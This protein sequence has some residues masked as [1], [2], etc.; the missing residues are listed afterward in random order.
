MLDGEAQI[1][2]MAAEVQVRV[3]PGVEFRGTA[4]GLAGADAPA[5]L[6][7]VVDHGHGDAVATLQLAEV[8]EQRRHLAGGVLVDPVQAHERVEDEQ[9]RLQLR[10]GLVEAGAVGLEI[11]AHRRRRDHLN[12]RYIRDSVCRCWKVASWLS[13][14]EVEGTGFGRGSWGCKCW[15]PSASSTK[16]G[17]EAGATVLELPR[18]SSRP[19]GNATSALTPRHFQRCALHGLR[20]GVEISREA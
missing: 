13:L 8:G 14:E 19:R 1:V 4:Q 18:Q 6:L 12:V 10:D 20:N 7:G 5:A 2:A 3:A 11:E 15:V 16:A 17:H 9:P